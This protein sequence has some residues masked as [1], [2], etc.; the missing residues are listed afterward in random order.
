MLEDSNHPDRDLRDMVDAYLDG[1]PDAARLAALEA[2]PPPDPAA[3]K[4]IVRY[5]RHDRA[6]R[7]EI[8]ARR[9]TE[10]ALAKLGAT[11]DGPANLK[12]PTSRFRPFRWVAAAAAIALAAGT[13]WIA[14]T[15]RAEHNQA[16]NPPA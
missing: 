16:V 11:D 15:Q 8:H 1:A 13:G 6:L 14:A 5:A 10:S 9:Q 3:R 12:L 7:M 4:F 2:R